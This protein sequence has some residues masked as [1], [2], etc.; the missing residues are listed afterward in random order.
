[1]ALILCGAVSAASYTVGPG[2]TYNYSSISSA[3]AAAKDG[4]NIMVY[5]NGSSSYSEYVNVNHKLNLTAN[6]KVIV[7][8]P[9]QTKNSLITITSGGSGS[10]IQG[11]TVT[12]SGVNTMNGIE[13]NG[14]DNCKILKNN[15]TGFSTGICMDDDAANNVITGNNIDSGANSVGYSYGI[16]LSGSSTAGNVISENIIKTTG[17][18]TGSSDGIA[19]YNSVQ[20]NIFSGNIINATHQG[21]GLSEGILIYSSNSNVVSGN[22]IAASGSGSSV[23]GIRISNKAN[24]N[25]II[26]NSIAADT[27]LYIDVAGNLANFNRIISSNKAIL[28]TAS[29][30]LNAQYNWYGSNADPG[31]KIQGNVNYGPWLMLTVAA[32]PG[33]VGTGSI[34]TITADF[35]HDSNG[36]THNPVS[37]YFPDGIGIHFTTNFGTVNSW[38]STNNGVAKSAF[39]SGS[40]G[41]SNI[42]VSADSQ[43]MGTSVKI[44]DV[45]PPKVM[46]TYPKNGAKKVSRTKTII[47][48][49]S[50]KIKKSINWSKIYVKDKHGKKVKISKSISGNTIYIKT[51]KRTSYSYYTVYIPAAA[52]KDY[53]DNNLKTKYTFKFK[54]GK[55]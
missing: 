4:D 22:I 6:G 53:A 44:V 45:T 28:N 25:N 49:F 21:T 29:G 5:S 13:L 9:D 52:L 10:T 17:T 24:G 34:S 11:F 42:S 37:G 18:G 54:T 36:G 30:N 48:K 47:I 23:R 41:I 40:T 1:M 35:T 7:Q 51:K 14:A 19:L 15:I 26:G 39:K 38:V 33:T 27:G 2:S 20:N 8:T 3:V 55:Y 32:S 31:S 46:S 16:D 50:E 12:T 43:I